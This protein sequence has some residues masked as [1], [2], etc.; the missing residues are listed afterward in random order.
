MDIDAFTAVHA[1][2]WDRLA[3]LTRRR[4]L[5]GA[6]A[7]ELVRL[8]QAVATHLSTARS[9]APDPAVVTR[10]SELL[11][12][13]RAKI[14]GSHEPAWRGVVRFAMVTAPAALYRIRWWAH[15]V[16]AAA[17]VVAV[18]TGVN[19]ATDPEALRAMGTPSFQEQYVEQAF[20]EYYDPGAGFAG[21]VWTNNFWIAWQCI[22]GGITGFF[23]LYVL[24]QN[25]VTV[26]SIGGMM[27]A[28]G[29]LD[30]FLTLIAPHGLLELTAIFVAGAAGLRF[31]WSWIDPGPLRRSTSLAREGRAL[32]TVAISLTVAL[33]VSGLVEGFVTG[34]S[35]FWWLKIVIGAIALAAFWAYVYVLGGRAVRDGE[36]GDLSADEAG[37][38]A[39]TAG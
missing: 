20:A 1:K 7:D 10:L 31:F 13:A 8:Y 26:G 22:G 37:A 30:T 28:H 38:Y 24:W 21:V 17:L 12:R 18:I 14:A 29:E 39:V 16:T 15:A 25:A 23:P 35:M 11:V 2:E 3:E 4:R 27:A 6:E 9:A 5:D 32:I 36:T 19:V 33:G 34:S